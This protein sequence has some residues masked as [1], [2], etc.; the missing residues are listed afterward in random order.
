MAKTGSWPERGVVVAEGGGATAVWGECKGSGAK[1]YLAA[2]HLDGPQGP[3][4][5]CSCPSRKIPCKHVL[6][7]LSLWSQEAVDEREDRPEWVATWLSGRAARAERAATGTVA[8]PA[9][10]KKAAATL[11]ARE[12][13]VTAGIEELRVWLHDQVDTGLAEVPRLGY[14]HW[15]RMAKRL[16]DA[17]A[18]GAASLVTRL[19]QRG[20]DEH[21]PDRLLERLGMLHLLVDGYLA[22]E[23]AD[24]RTLAVLRS[25]VGISTRTEEILGSG[26]R[27]RD[28]WRV[29]GYRDALTP[30]GMRSRRTWLHGIDTD[31]PALSLTFARP[32]Q[33]PDSPFRA[34]TEVEGEL[35]FHPDGRRAV[36]AGS[37]TERPAA[38]PAGGTV[39]QALDAHARALADDPWLE[40]WPVVVADAVPAQDGGW[41]VAD[42]GGSALPLDTGSLW[43]FLAITGGR[44]TTVAAEWSPK[45]GLSLM[46]LWDDDGKAIAL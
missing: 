10:P 42:A 14:R 4:Y 8:A 26:E 18:P 22:R 3:G 24:E 37:M 35:V 39:D 28:T 16:V 7:L 41:Y 5:K 2:V 27:V 19:P 36:K 11:K 6:A 9:D 15:D 43:R 1:P 45:T 12:D 44:P 31:R 34:G 33:T 30:D 38:R 21:W 17:K 46:T 29:L 25:R 40:G 23:G 32:D 20:G 13:A